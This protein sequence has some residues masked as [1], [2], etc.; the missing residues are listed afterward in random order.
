MKRPTLVPA[1]MVVRM[2]SASNMM[3][4]W[5]HSAMAVLPPSTFEKSCAM[6]T[7]RLGAPP[8]RD[9]SESSPTRDASSRISC[10]VTVNPHC[11][12]ARDA[13]SHASGRATPERR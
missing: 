2:N 7:A 3:A 5:Y 9:S 6:P 12:I 11:A 4:K 10:G 8:V 1:S 13:L